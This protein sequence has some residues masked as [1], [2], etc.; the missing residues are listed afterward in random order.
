MGFHLDGV[1]GQFESRPVAWAAEKLPLAE[2]IDSARRIYTK[3][4][5]S[6][7]PPLDMVLDLTD[8]KAVRQALVAFQLSRSS[9]SDVPKNI[10]E[11]MVAA[12]EDAPTPNYDTWQMKTDS[13]YDNVRVIGD[14]P[15]S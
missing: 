3:L 1:D 10:S 4:S 8:P 15:P 7:D 9:V 2:D 11:R 5:D 13:Y 12:G 6:D 14:D